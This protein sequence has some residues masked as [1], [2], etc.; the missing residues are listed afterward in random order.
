MRLT[1][2]IALPT[3]LE[4]CFSA[5]LLPLDEGTV[6]P[7]EPKSE[8]TEVRVTAPRVGGP[9]PRCDWNP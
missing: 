6:T 9:P 5:R 8:A 1:R 4:I 2:R 3:G 7:E